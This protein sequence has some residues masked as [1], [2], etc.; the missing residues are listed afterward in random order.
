MEC[1]TQEKIVYA[2]NYIVKVGDQAPDF[3]IKE[4]GGST[5]KL[6]SLRGKVVMLQFTASWSGVCRQEMLS[7]AQRRTI[8]RVAS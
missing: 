8:I 6:S 5:Y 2:D 7:R 1:Y 3:L 4:A